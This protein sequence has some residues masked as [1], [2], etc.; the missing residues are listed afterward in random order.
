MATMAVSTTR[1][2]SRPIQGTFAV[3]GQTVRTMGRK[4]SMVVV[5][6]TQTVR[7]VGRDLN[8]PITV[9]LVMSRFTGYIVATGISVSATVNRGVHKIIAA[10]ASLIISVGTGGLKYY[11]TLVVPFVVTPSLTFGRVFFRTLSAGITTGVS[12]TTQIF[13]LSADIVFRKGTMA[14][15]WVVGSVTGRWKT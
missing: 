14:F 1:V 7:Q 12:V 5:A 6:T 13:Q 9:T 10:I 8:V 4:C 11:I 15:Q 2:I 3:A